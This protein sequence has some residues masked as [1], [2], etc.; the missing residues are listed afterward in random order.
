MEF[1]GACSWCTRLRF[2]RFQGP[3]GRLGVYD[4]WGS[5]AS[6]V[7]SGSVVYWIYFQ[8]CSF[9]FRKFQRKTIEDALHIFIHSRTLAIDSWFFENPVSTIARLQH[10]F[11][12]VARNIT[13]CHATISKQ[14]QAIVRIWVCDGFPFAFKIIQVWM[15]LKHHK[16]ASTFQQ[17]DTASGPET[18]GTWLLKPLLKEYLPMQHLVARRLLQR[19]LRR[20]KGRQIPR[21][22]SG[23]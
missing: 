11:C 1:W 12:G 3:L 9:F 14:Y 18:A 7:P 4:T 23:S 10:I 20:H 15:S 8:R 13:Q 22:I 19:M 16:M 6:M 5:K 2:E 17:K 21:L